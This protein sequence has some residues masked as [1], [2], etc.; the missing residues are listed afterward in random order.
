MGL[1]AV[2]AGTLIVE[3]G[4]VLATAQEFGIAVMALAA[5]ALLGSLRQNKR[6]RLAAF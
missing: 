1:P 5:L 2:V 3:Q 6:P 4:N